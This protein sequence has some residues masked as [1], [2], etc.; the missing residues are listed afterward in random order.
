MLGVSAAT[1]ILS[2]LFVLYYI[3][4][5]LLGAP[6]LSELYATCL[7]SFWLT[8]LTGLPL[9]IIYRGESHLRE[10]LFEGR[11]RGSTELLAH[12]AIFG[13][14]IGAWLGA[15]VIPLDWDRWWQRYPFP[16]FVG[17]SCGWA[18]GLC[19]A[20]IQWILRRFRREKLP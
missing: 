7:L 8:L 11:Y 19:L 4:A 16:N 18:L 14:L 6:L 13:A 17:A 3:V 9:I 15:F 2:Q 20:E 1:Q 12:R 5:V 10:F